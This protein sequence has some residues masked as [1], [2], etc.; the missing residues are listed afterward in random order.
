MNGFADLRSTAD[1]M[2]VSAVLKVE[3]AQKR[4]ASRLLKTLL[5]VCYSRSDLDEKTGERDIGLRVR[6]AG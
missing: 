4:T 6:N 3:I 1:W 5:Q 2:T